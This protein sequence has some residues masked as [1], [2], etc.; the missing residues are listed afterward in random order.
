MFIKLENSG[1]YQITYIR[2]SLVTAIVRERSAVLLQGIIG[3]TITTLFPAEFANYNEASSF[4]NEVA[5]IIT[6]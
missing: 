1:E 6:K 5:G 3:N 4:A 2:K